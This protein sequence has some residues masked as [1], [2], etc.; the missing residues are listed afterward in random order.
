MSRFSSIFDCMCCLENDQY[1]SLIT[2]LLVLSSITF[3]GGNRFFVCKSKALHISLNRKSFIIFFYFSEIEHDKCKISWKVPLSSYENDMNFE[4][5]LNIFEFAAEKS[6]ELTYAIYASKHE[7][8][9]QK[10]NSFTS[11]LATIG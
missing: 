6:I 10:K 8:K 11:S 9:K 1:H 4:R 3:S 2:G 5:D 7:K